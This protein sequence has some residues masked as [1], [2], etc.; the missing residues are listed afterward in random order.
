MKA[1]E[2]SSTKTDSLIYVDMDGVLAD[3]FGEVARQHHVKKFRD[4]H[5][6]GGISQHAK[7][8]GF[9]R[10][11][12]LLPNATHLIKG[13]LQR[14]GEYNILSSPL[15]SDVEGSS[16]E[17]TQWLNHYFKNMPPEEIL[18]TH[19][20]Y[21]YAKRPDSTPNILID[22]YPTNIA[23][24]RSWGGIGILYKDAECDRVL[25][26]LDLALVGRIHPHMIDH[27]VEIEHRKFP[28]VVSGRRLLKFVKGIH[29]EFHL[30]DPVL[31]HPFWQFVELPLS[32]INT[33]E[34]YH[35]DDPHR[36]YISLDWEH[37]N[38]IT[39]EDIAKKPVVV[40]GNGWALDGN[41][42]ITRARQ[43]GLE[44][45]PAYVPYQ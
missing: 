31:E 9:F 11:L 36:R 8:S 5:K 43:L 44:T 23:L 41:H 24:W 17:K 28:H 39:P 45:I 35:Q 30:D 16:D 21:Q 42:R 20:K 34:Y 29:N 12:P 15:M 3:F 14:A 32:D 18:F 27:T 26:E 10:N 1:F 25:K 40:D 2:V 33:P 13:I 6:G 19:E 7:K 37:I 22:D 38:R 4:V